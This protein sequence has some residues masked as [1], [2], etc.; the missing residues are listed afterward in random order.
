[1]RTTATKTERRRRR[2]YFFFALGAWDSVDPASFF[3]V[4]E[5]EGSASFFAANLAICGD[6]CLGFLG[7][8][9]LSGF[10]RDCASR[11]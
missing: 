9:V 8:I 4:D 11:N 1:M 5:D 3:T 7:T 2:P 6:V 10:A